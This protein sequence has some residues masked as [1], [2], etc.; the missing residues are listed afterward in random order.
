MPSKRS[1]SAERDKKRKMR[2]TRSLEKWK[3]ACAAD[4][5]RKRNKKSTLTENGAAAEREDQL[6]KLSFRSR[7]AERKKKRLM[8]SKR[9]LEKLKDVRAADRERKRREKSTLKEEGADEEKERERKRKEREENIKILKQDYENKKEISKN[10]NEMETRKRVLTIDKERKRVER[11]EIKDDVEK[12]KEVCAKDKDRKRIER[13]KI[14][15]DDEKWKDVCAKDKERKREERSSQ[16]EM[17][18]EYGNKLAKHKRRE[19]RVQRTGKE[20]LQQNL[21]FKKGMRLLRKEGRLIKYSD[22]TQRNVSET[23]DW[24]RFM[25]KSKKHD[26][27]VK[28]KNPDLVQRLNEESR[29]EKEN[30]RKKEEQ[31]RKGEEEKE[32]IRM[33]RNEE[34]GGEWVFNTE[35]SEFFWVG[36]RDPIDDDPPFIELSEQEELNLKIQED[37]RLDTIIK[38]KK[39][40]ARERRRQKLMEQKAA[41]NYPIDPI[42]ERELCEYEKLR[43]S[44]IQEREKA[45]A[46]S[47]FFDDIN[48]FKRKIGMSN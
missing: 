37:M 5:E 42:P 43:L 45:M 6:E 10:K 36:E 27:M 44:N 40:E 33:M 18:E 12:W 26:D 19:M 14:K 1:R 23:T 48:D 39:D 32:E 22:R 4:R 13:D 28:E 9:S 3:D 46:E 41:M 30:L 31:R 25:E 29:V 47:G 24:Q 16:N 34:E 8:R 20:K 15:D 11:D 17:E 7:S 38:E 35:Y 21:I 2:A